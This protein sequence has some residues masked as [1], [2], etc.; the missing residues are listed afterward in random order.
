MP[1]IAGADLDDLFLSFLLDLPAIRVLSRVSKEWA[2]IVFTPQ[3]WANSCLSIETCVVDE[4]VWIAHARTWSRVS[5]LSVGYIQSAYANIAGVPRYISWR[6]GLWD[7][8]QNGRCSWARMPYVSHIHGHELRPWLSLSVNPMAPAFSL[9]LSAV[10]LGI[11]PISIGWTNAVNPGQLA[12]VFYDRPTHM[13]DIDV[14]I[15]YV[16]L[17]HTNNLFTRRMLVAN[18]RH[19]P[20][21]HYLRADG[22][23][24]AIPGR[25]QCSIRLQTPANVTLCCEPGENVVA[26]FFNGVRRAV[27]PCP[28]E[29]NKWPGWP[30]GE[31]ASNRVFALTM[32]HKR[33][34]VALIPVA[35]HA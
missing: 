5:S 30:H 20:G 24:W 4:Q 6:W 10:D 34:E 22:G 9:T 8:E 25:E 32:S 29:L 19:G 13:K 23:S 16:N 31:I 33:P 35:S 11:S 15:M 21:L 2:R 3:A 17:L 27:L 18:W 26:F 28:F 1:A 14:F 7:L 12:R